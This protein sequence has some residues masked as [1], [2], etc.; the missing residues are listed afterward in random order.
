MTIIHWVSKPSDVI[1]NGYGY[2]FHNRMMFKFTEKA[3]VQ[4]DDNSKIALQI[5]SADKFVP[6]EG[7]VNVLFSMWEFDDLPKSYIRSINS[8][9]ALVVP[10]TF[11]KNLFKRYTTKPIYVCK[12]GVNPEDY[13][14]KD[15]QVGG[16]KKFRYLWCGASNPRKG[17][18]TILEAVKMADLLP[19]ME[20][21]IKTTM[22]KMTYK[23]WLKAVWKNRYDIFFDKD[24]KG[25]VRLAHAVSAFR[26]IPNNKMAEKLTVMGKYKNVL[27]DTRNLSKE[28]L[29]ELYQSAHCFLLPSWGEGWGLTLCEAMATGC[30]SIGTGVTGEADFFD[31]TVG[32]MVKSSKK[33]LTLDNYEGLKTTASIPDTKDFLDKMLYVAMNYE[34]AKKKGKKAHK[35]IH[36]K[37]TWERSGKRLAEILKEIHENVS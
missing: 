22:P 11:V 27:F 28:E 3:G 24:D 37:F 29:I 30:P 36:E 4:Y 18:Q 1:G 25:K 23:S 31:D 19:D 16:G 6:L 34:E 12:E 9:D 2:S 7:K 15:R 14:F 35:R 20:I 8:A 5:T 17:Y 21:Y 33:E 10:S 32:Y 13:P 26:R